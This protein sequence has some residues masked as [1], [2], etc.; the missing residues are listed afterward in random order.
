[1]KINTTLLVVLLKSVRTVFGTPRKKKSTHL[2]NA[3][4]A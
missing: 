3:G 4:E 2:A 1:M